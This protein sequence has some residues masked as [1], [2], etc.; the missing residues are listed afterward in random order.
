M[1]TNKELEKAVITILENT[2]VL[3]AK[4]AKLEVDVKTILG[5]V[6]DPNADATKAGMEKIVGVMKTI[7]EELLKE[8]GAKCVIPDPLKSW[9]RIILNNGKAISVKIIE[10][11]FRIRLRGPEGELLKEA[12]SISMNGLLPALKALLPDAM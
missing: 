11:G 5:A 9:F 2:T 3:L 4:V 6:V 1:L 10:N 7:P 8:L 12:A